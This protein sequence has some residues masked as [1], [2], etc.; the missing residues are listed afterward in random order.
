MSL[1]LCGVGCTADPFKGM[2]ANP[3]DRAAPV[4]ASLEAAGM[5]LPHM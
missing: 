5:R 2:I 3:E 1:Y 4:K